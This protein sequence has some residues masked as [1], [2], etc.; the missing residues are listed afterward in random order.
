MPNGDFVFERDED[1]KSQS[2]QTFLNALDA[3]IQTK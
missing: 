2:I 1:L 3:E